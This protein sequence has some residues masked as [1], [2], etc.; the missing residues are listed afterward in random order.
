MYKWDVLAQRNHYAL[1]TVEVEQDDRIE[2][3]KAAQ[4]R[5]S[6]DQTEWTTED[7]GGFGYGFLAVGPSMLAND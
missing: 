1:I 5:L 7:G 4:T 3:I 6:S 2:A